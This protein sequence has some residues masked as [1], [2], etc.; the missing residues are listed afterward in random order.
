[1]NNIISKSKFKE[2]ADSPSKDKADLEKLLGKL[3]ARALIEQKNSSPPP[4]P[5]HNRFRDTK[6]FRISVHDV[7]DNPA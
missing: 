3:V 4:S 1:M 2:D 7:D 5:S 6:A